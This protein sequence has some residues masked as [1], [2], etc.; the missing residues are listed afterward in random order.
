MTVN[1]CVTLVDHVLLF[2]SD[3]RTCQV[4]DESELLSYQQQLQEWERLEEE[5][6]HTFNITDTPEKVVLVSKLKVEML[7]FRCHKILWFFRGP[8]PCPQA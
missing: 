6:R 4:T 7:V 5:E 8:I 2:L 3:W 1:V